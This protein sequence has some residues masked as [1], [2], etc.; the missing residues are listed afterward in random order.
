MESKENDGQGGGPGGDRLEADVLREE[1]GNARECG[2]AD[3]GSA[4]LHADGVGGESLAET[5]GSAG[6]QAGENGSEAES[7]EDER[8]AGDGFGEIEQK[9]DRS[10]N[11][12]EETEANEA[13]DT[14][15]FDDEA[16][17]D[18][19]GGDAGPIGGDEKAGAFFGEAATFFEDGE[20]PLTDGYF[21]AG[22][23][24]KEEDMQPDQRMTECFGGGGFGFVWVLRLRGVGPQVA[25]E[26][27]EKREC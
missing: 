7:A 22:V 14:E 1:S 21:E 23:D 16:E 26:C 8:N 18:A 10:Q 19:S 20:T 2:G 17:C 11:G 5:F 24:E 25:G 9:E 15:A 12:S 3:H 27:E 13:I 6:H 4:Y